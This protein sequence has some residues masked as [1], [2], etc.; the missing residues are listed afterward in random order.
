MVDI[1][2]LKDQRVGNLDG[3][4][5]DRDQNSPVYLVI[6]ASDASARG[7]TTKHSYLVPVGD[8]WFDETTRSIRIDAPKRERIAFD[9][10]EFERMTST[11]ADEYERRV[12]ANCCPEVGFHRDGRPNYAR[13]QQ[14]TCPTWLRPGAA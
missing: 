11:Q 7:T 10:V 6:A 4:V 14:F 12:L 1:L 3:M 2:D 5:V 9:P 8:A 13:L